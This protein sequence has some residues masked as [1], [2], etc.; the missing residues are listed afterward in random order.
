LYRFF[1]GLT[2]LLLNCNDEQ[3]W[4]LYQASSQRYYL[5]NQLKIYQLS[6]SNHKYKLEQT[7]DFSSYKLTSQ[8]PRWA[9]YD[10]DNEINTLAIFPKLFPLNETDYAVGI[11]QTWQEGYSGGGLTEEVADFLQLKLNGQYQQVFQNIPLSMN[12][13]I[14]A[15]FSEKD[16]K[17]AR[18]QCHDEYA[19]DMQISYVKAGTWNVK[20]HYQVNY[21]PVSDSGIKPV[22]L[23]KNYLLNENRT[24][25]IVLPKAWD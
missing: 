2:I 7:W 14:R 23:R 4:A 25:A 11:V 21:S 19:L 1:I 22:S 6:M 20:Y 12:R 18:E 3:E 8:R 17:I 24:D 16:Y 5:I 13:F 9:S 15:R 10:Q